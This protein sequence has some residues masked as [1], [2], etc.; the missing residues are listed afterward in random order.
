ML[1]LFFEDFADVV[2]FVD[3][4]DSGEDMRISQALIDMVVRDLLNLMVLLQL[5][6]LVIRVF[7]EAKKLFEVDVLETLG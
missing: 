1:D 4:E 5:Q 3:A 6:D 2:G 7:R